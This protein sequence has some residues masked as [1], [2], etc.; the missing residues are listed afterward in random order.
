VS[1]KKTEDVHVGFKS[2]LLFIGM[3]LGVVYTILEF[4]TSWIGAEE[5]TIAMIRKLA[6]VWVVLLIVVIALAY[7]AH[8]LWKVVFLAEEKYIK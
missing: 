7:I 5:I 3:L 2:L 4:V 1:E 8:M 6:T